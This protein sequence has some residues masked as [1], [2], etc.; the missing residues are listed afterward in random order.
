M[1]AR[2]MMTGRGSVRNASQENLLGPQ[3]ACDH[4]LSGVRAVLL[5][6]TVGLYKSTYQPRYP[7]YCT[8]R[9]SFAGPC[10]VVSYGAR[11]STAMLGWQPQQARV[12]TEYT[13]V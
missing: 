6:R 7:L 5:C 2:V 13:V 8:G 9:G 12:C 4:A 10:D 11:P 1:V 3:S